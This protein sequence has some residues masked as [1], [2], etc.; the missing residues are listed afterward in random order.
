MLQ[1][2][3]LHFSSSTSQSPASND[4][5]P[6]RCS[7]NFNTSSTCIWFISV[8]GAHSLH[9]NLSSDP[10]FC[11]VIRN[12][13]PRRL[14]T[15]L[16]EADLT[17]TPNTTPGPESATSHNRVRSPLTFEFLSLM[18]TFVDIYLSLP[19]YTI[20][21]VHQLFFLKVHSHHN[22]RFTHTSYGGQP[23][24][25]PH[26]KAFQTNKACESDLQKIQCFAWAY[27]CRCRWEAQASLESVREM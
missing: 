5:A 9:R 3:P 2:F 12:L 6:P 25:P 16:V 27:R 4:P 1:R 14:R 15:S 22:V 7:I 23:Q 11:I 19:R 13:S 21:E 10:G 17:K 26:Q 20:V 18:V 8:G 24:I